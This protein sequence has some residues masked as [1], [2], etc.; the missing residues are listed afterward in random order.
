MDLALW[1]DIS[2]DA[3]DATRAI[4]AALEVQKDAHSFQRN[5]TSEGLLIHA[6]W[7][8]L[9]GSTEVEVHARLRRPWPANHPIRLTGARTNGLAPRSAN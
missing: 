4:L 3:E 5:L 8:L 6:L 2:G 7:A 9:D 1:I